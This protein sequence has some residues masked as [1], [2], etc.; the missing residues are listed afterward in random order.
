MREVDFVYGLQPVTQPSPLCPLVSA[1]YLPALGLRPVAWSPWSPRMVEAGASAAVE[2]VAN[3]HC[4]QEHD[5]DPRSLPAPM[6]ASAC[7][8]DLEQ[9]GGRDI[10]A[11]VLI[12]EAVRW[13]AG[14]WPAGPRTT[15]PALGQPRQDPGLTA[16]WRQHPVRRQRLQLN[17]EF[18]LKL[19]PSGRTRLVLL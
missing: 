13:T 3:Q 5:G 11:V 7:A 4:V 12:V 19:L 15:S 16:R 14:A 1:L 6:R 17:V 8:T 2:P 18:Q 9:H 10:L